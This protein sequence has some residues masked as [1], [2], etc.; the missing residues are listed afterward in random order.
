MKIER[1]KFYR[2]EDGTKQG[3]MDGYNELHWV[4]GQACAETPGW[5]WD[6]SVAE[7]YPAPHG[8]L[9]A[10]WHDIDLTQ[11]TTPFGLL[12]EETQKALKA[13]EGEIEYYDVGGHWLVPVCGPDWVVS[14]TYRAKPEPK[15]ETFTG[16]AYANAY[17]NSSCPFFS[18]TKCGEGIIG[19]WSAEV[20]DGKPVRIVWG[21]SV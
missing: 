3:P 17:G 10:E 7:G 21:A 5:K 16:Q 12:D 14:L 4:K 1:G 9:I 15:R 18:D 11:I 2:A 20:V 19:K 8:A 13:H 6:G